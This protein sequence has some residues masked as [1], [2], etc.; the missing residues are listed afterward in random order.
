MKH[1]YVVR[2][3]RYWWIFRSNFGVDSPHPQKSVHNTMATYGQLTPNFKGISDEK[4]TNFSQPV[5]Q[6]KH[7]HKS[8]LETCG[9]N[10][11]LVQAKCVFNRIYVLMTKEER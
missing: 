9:A 3:Q 5:N 10:S 8:C 4:Q 2:L 1:S 11:R 7:D 6:N